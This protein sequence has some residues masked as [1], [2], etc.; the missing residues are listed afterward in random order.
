MKIY[1]ASSWR[2]L[3]QPEVVRVLREA[4]HR[5]YDFRSPPHR[6]GFAWSDID[7]QWEKWTVR[8]F[9]A[10][11]EHPVAKAGFREDFEALR[12]ADACVLVMPAGRSAAL[13]FGWAAGAG[14][15]TAVLLARQEPELMLKIGE[16]RFLSL[17]ELVD[18]LHS[19][20]M[21]P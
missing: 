12:A 7:L 18:W 11:L 19:L 15:R 3:V 8:D 13:E 6:E 14:K 17:S 4:G 1:V 10:A 5:V 20:E 21:Y 2:N 9:D 16:I